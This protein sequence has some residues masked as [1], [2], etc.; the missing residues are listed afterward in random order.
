MRA[1]NVWRMSSPAIH[2]LV[3]GFTAGDAISSES[4][5]LRALFT[6]WGHAS[7]IFCEKKRVSPDLRKT[8]HDISELNAMLRPE[9]VAVLHLS[10]GSPA[11]EVFPLLKCRKLIVYHNITPPHYFRGLN[12]SIAG[13]LKKGLDQ[14]TAL[15]GS[16]EV[17]LADS[18]FNAG[19]IEAMGHRGARVMP[20]ML[21]RAQWEGDADRRVVDEY[22][23]GM[24]NILFVG[25]CA[26]NKRIE[27]LLQAF[28]FVKKYV[29]SRARLIH[30]GSWNGLERYHALLRARVGELGLRDVV[31]AGSVSQSQLRAFYQ[32]ARVFLCMSEHEGFCIPLLEAMAH[33]VPVMAFAAGAV[34]ETMGGAG[35]VFREKQFDAVAEMIGRVGSDE[36]LRAAV[37]A[38][39]SERLKAYFAQDIPALWR[40]ALAPLLR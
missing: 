37:I 30:V 1:A 19:E 21:D 8:V 13:F 22:N 35:V 17:V 10:I 26:P 16:A 25:R 29:N 6:S 36:A 12:E 11:N 31:F 4:R 32:C 33:R 14:A 27:D 38:R 28:Y 39:Q 9:D 5:V 20:L 2:Q 24:T 18:T 15:A 3:A 23:D 34:P 40:A 7:D